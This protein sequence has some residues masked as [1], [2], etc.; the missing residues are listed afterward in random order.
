MHWLGGSLQSMHRLL[1]KAKA[2][3]LIE[4]KIAFSEE[5]QHQRHGMIPISA[6]S[7]GQHK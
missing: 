7:G 2:M 3:E 5:E 1:L 4:E 6:R